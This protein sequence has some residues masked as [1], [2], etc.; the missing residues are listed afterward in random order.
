MRLFQKRVL[1]ARVALLVMAFTML[2][3]FSQ[4]VLAVTTAEIQNYTEVQDDWG[5]IAVADIAPDLKAKDEVDPAEIDVADVGEYIVVTTYDASGTATDKVY[6]RGVVQAAVTNKNIG[7]LG[8]A[9]I[10]ADVGAANDLVSGFEPVIQLIIGVL[11]WVIV[12]GLP[13]ITALDVCYIT[14]PF[15]REKAESAKM[16]GNSAMCKTGRDGSTKIRWIS[17]EAQHAVAT[18]DLENGKS[19]LKT[20]LT[21]RIGAFIMVAIILYLL[22]G[23]QITVVTELAVKLVSGI[24]NIISGLAS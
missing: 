6:K 22:I 19:P 20:Y 15:V 9:N 1:L 5:G 16:S 14:I 4:S 11:A 12:I 2:F 23:G 13:L 21:S 10:R 8:G 24:M 18:L 17:D 3:G 7:D